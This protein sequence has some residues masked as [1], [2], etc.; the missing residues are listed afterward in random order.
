MRV[1]L[2]GQP[3]CGKSTLFNQ[4]AG[5]KAHTGNFP[6]TTV[7]F[8]E[9]SVRVIGEK[10]DL[11]DLP[12]T[13]SLTASNMAEKEVIRY[14]SSHHV[15]VILNLVDASH[16]VQGLEL[17]LELL[18]LGKPLVIGMNMMDEAARMGIIIDGPHLQQILGV[19]VLP[20]IASKGRGIKPLFTTILDVSRNCTQVKRIPYKNQQIEGII[21]ELSKNLQ[22]LDVEWDREAL[23]IRLLEDGS[24]LLYGSDI[25]P[26]D[27]ESIVQPYNQMITKQLGK[28]PIWIFSEERH[29]LARDLTNRVLTR[30]EERFTW[31]TRADDVLLH[32][33]WGYVILL[34]ILWAFFQVVYLAGSAI[35]GP[36]ISFFDGMIISLSSIT[37]TGSLLT[38]ILTGILQGIS[39]GVAI[40]LPYLLPFL[41]GMGFLEDVGYLPRL[42]FMMDSLMQR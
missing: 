7:T 21:Q 19:P 17:T 3:N 18:E 15:D 40:V 1:A 13:Y 10:I 32:P 16:L 14:L 4:V 31:Q 9:S 8:T 42:A 30:G 12:G 34:G 11:V 35:E 20:L 37:G 39:G 36:L 27:L 23:A 24:E 28:T 29:A 6:G 5:Y 26:L 38:D 25:D 33:F 22:D 2:I 41:L